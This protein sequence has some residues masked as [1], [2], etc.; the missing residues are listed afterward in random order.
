MCAHV[1]ADDGEARTVAADL[2]VEFAAGATERDAR[3]L[4]P[5]GELDRLSARGLR[6]SRYRADYGGADVIGASSDTP[7][8]QEETHPTTGA[9]L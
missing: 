5:R 2:A 7:V 6:P 4:L 8:T 1:I 3:R 9:V